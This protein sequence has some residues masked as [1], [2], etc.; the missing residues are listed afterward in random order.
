MN[1][2]RARC[3]VFSVVIAG[4]LLFALYLLLPDATRAARANPGDLFVTHTG[5]GDCSQA[6]PCD[7]QSA[8]GLAGEGDSIYLASGVYTGAGGAVVTVTQ[9]INLYGG[10]DGAPTGSVTRDPA[11]YTS[12]LDGQSQ[13]R[14]IYIAPGTS[15]TLDGLRI[16]NGSVLTAGPAARKGAGLSFANPFRCESKVTGLS[17]TIR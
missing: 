6:S 11:T 5:G 4:V 14:V 16:A 1:F 10:W 8:L 17:E 7:L 12:T 3:I 13:R 9:S 2:D 15:V